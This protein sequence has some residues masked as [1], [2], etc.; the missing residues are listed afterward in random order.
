MC[1]LTSKSRIHSDE[2]KHRV[3]YVDEPSKGGD[4]FFS[5][6]FGFCSKSA[7]KEKTTIIYE[8]EQHVSSIPRVGGQGGGI[9]W[10]ILL[11]YWWAQEESYLIAQRGI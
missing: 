6:R 7:F 3:V 2:N 9:L 11:N 4:R 10:T 8:L 1:N 5:S